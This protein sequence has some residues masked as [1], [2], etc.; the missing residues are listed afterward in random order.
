MTKP[1]PDG[2]HSLS[3]H[4]VVTDGAAAIEFLLKLDKSP[5]NESKR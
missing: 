2:F 1:I 3:P 5:V 4:I